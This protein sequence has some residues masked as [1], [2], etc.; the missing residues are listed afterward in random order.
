MQVAKMRHKHCQQGLQGAAPIV[1]TTMETNGDRW[2]L[3]H[4]KGVRDEQEL[5]KEKKPV[6]Q[7]G[8]GFFQE[9]REEILILLHF[10]CQPL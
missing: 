8:T 1:L 5:W 2:G 6:S 7:K 3:A 9:R 4:K 10:L